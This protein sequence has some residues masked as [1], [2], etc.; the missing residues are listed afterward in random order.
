[1]FRCT[2]NAYMSAIILV[3]AG[4]KVVTGS[5]VSDVVGQVC[6]WIDGKFPMRKRYSSRAVFSQPGDK[7]VKSCQVMRKHPG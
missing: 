3:M 6:G 5:I 2:N 4:G 7:H 1:M